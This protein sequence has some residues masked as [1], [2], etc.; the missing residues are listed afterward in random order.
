MLQRLPHAD[1]RGQ[2][3]PPI[4]LVAPAHALLS[5][6]GGSVKDAG[7]P[8]RSCSSHIYNPSPGSFLPRS[9][10]LRAWAEVSPGASAEIS[11]EGMGRRDPGWHFYPPWPSTQ[12]FSTP[13]PTSP[14]ISCPENYCRNFCLGLSQQ[15]SNPFLTTPIPTPHSLSPSLEENKMEGSQHFLQV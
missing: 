11:S 12:Y 1:L 8:C 3:A 14:P 13:S 4:A 5:L 9:L 6:K 10:H 15:W 2:A 7:P